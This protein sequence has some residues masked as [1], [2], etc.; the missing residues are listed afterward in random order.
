MSSGSFHIAS[1]HGRS[2][3]VVVDGV[4]YEFRRLGWRERNRVVH[5]AVALTPGA[6]TLEPVA[7]AERMLTAS[8]VAVWSGAERQLMTPERCLD[9]PVELGDTLMAAAVHVN[10]R[11]PVAS[12]ERPLD[13][14]HNTVEMNGTR[15]TLSPWSWGTRNR[16]LARVAPTDGSGID[17]ATFHELVL[18]TICTAIAD[19]PPPAGWLD[20]LA[21]DDGDALLDVALRLG[22]LDQVALDQI[23]E[24]LLAEQPHDAIRMYE[25][26]KHFG[27]T[28]NQVRDQLASDIDALWTIHQAMTPPP[29]TTTATTTAQT[30]T[31][32]ENVILAVDD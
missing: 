20:D 11:L 31:D 7:F 6:L 2:V 4:E 23:T 30:W 12:S 8:L 29:E 26:C 22:G 3:V 18:G 19:A 17:V 32:G 16:V 25:I 28:P 1:D 27:W 15:Y 9:L 21:A 13:E 14:R 10:R 24:A 5:G